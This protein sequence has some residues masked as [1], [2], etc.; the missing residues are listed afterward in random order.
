MSVSQNRYSTKSEAIKNPVDFLH[1][2]IT[3]ELKVEQA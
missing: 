1:Y 3:S 2:Y